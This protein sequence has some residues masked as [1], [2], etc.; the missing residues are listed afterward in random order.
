MPADVPKP[1]INEC[2]VLGATVTLIDGLITDCGK[3]ARE[4]IEKYARFDVSTLRE[5]N[6]G[7]RPRKLNSAFF[8]SPG[9]SA[10]DSLCFP[11]IIERFPLFFD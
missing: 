8:S 10:T 6:S 1:F 5:R 11:L 2:R 3:A 9:S 4:G 7:D